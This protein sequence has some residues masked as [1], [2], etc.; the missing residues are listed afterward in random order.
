MVSSQ[1]S[2]ELAATLTG[3]SGD[4]SGDEASPPY[5]IDY[6]AVHKFGW[7]RLLSIA[8][9]LPGG[10]D[11][12][13]EIP[14][15]AEVMPLT[16]ERLDVGKREVERGRVV[17][18][19]HVDMREELAAID[20]RQDEVEVERVTVD[21]VVEASPGLREED[22]VLIVP[23]LEERLVLTKQLVLKE[24]L[25]IRTRTR[26]EAFRQP[27]QLRS[28]RAEISRTPFDEPRNP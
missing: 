17:V 1:C 2:K 23:I 20:L 8:V 13:G 25:R 26:I 28:E 3:A 10:G 21:R 19:T 11:P 18:R 4:R 5:L 16:E 27:V 9:H 24:E 15:Q 7:E 14:M 12:M 22:G 6:L